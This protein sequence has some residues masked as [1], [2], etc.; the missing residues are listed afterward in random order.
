MESY[1]VHDGVPE[2]Q[3]FHHEVIGFVPDDCPLTEP[4]DPFTAT[5]GGVAQLSPV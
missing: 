2:A 3:R 4:Q 5:T 1:D